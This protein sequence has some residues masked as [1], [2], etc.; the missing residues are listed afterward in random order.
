MACM[1][2]TS[3]SNLSHRQLRL[4]GAG[5]DTLRL[6]DEA[7]KIVDKIIDK[8]HNADTE[9]RR[10]GDRKLEQQAR[11]TEN[12]RSQAKDKNQHNYEIIDQVSDKETISLSVSAMK[13][14]DG[15]NENSVDIEQE[16]NNAR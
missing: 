13:T 8:A 7:D 5:H 12:W 10:S 4:T 14:T 15:A 16:I 9:E 11:R 2:K 1:G 6:R 3:V